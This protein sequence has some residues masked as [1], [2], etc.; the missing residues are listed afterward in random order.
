MRQR[1]GLV[2]PWHF[3]PLDTALHCSRPTE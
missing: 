3:W 2:T 1:T